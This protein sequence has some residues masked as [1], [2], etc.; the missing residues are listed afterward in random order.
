[1]L[2]LGL[3]FLI[4]MLMARSLRADVSR[5]AIFRLCCVSTTPIL[6]ASMLLPQFLSQQGLVY[7]LLA[8]GYIYFALSAQD[9]LP[10]TDQ[11]DEY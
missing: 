4:G 8:V 10:E 11:G 7:L 9:S 3:Y 5:K 2:M 6:A 1:M